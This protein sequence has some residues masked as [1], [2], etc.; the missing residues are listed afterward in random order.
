MKKLTLTQALL[1]AGLVAAAGVAQAETFDTPQQAGEMSTMTHGVPNVETNNIPNEGPN[2]LVLGA[3]PAVVTTHS[4][5]MTP[6]YQYVLPAPVVTHGHWSVPHA[7]ATET[8]N[9]PER[10]GEASTMTGGVPNALPNNHGH[11]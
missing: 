5:V 7:N 9:V 8:S 10:A 4:Y 3:G 6:S 1:A 2:T 11:F